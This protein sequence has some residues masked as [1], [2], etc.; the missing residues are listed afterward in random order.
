[1]ADDVLQAIVIDSGSGTTKAGFA[2]DDP[3]R[4]VIPSIVGRPR[5]Q[6]QK[7]VYVG[8]E[9]ISKAS[10]LALKFPIEHSYISNW[11]DIEKIWQH[12]FTKELHATP[13]KHPVLLTEP[14]RNPK[15]NR[16]KMMQIMFERF[17]TP[18][19]YI[20]TGAVLSL[21]ASGRTTGIVLDSGDGTTH[22]VPIYEGHALP[23][24]ITHI[25]L[26]G[27]ELNGFIRK[28]LTDRGFI[29]SSAEERNIIRDIKEKLCYVALDFKQEMAT[30]SSSS[31]LE[32][33][34]KLPDG[35]VITI[36]NERFRCPEALFQPSFLGME[37]AGIHETTY[38]SIM[39]CDVDLRKRLFANVVLSGGTTTFP[40]IA[41]RL[42]KEITSLAPTGM[43]VKINTPLERRC[44][45]WYGGSMLASMP[46]FMQMCVRK[47]TYDEIG[48]SIVHRMCY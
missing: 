30:A 6:G 25:D 36:G 4:A 24:G 39:K 12:I 42:E 21:Y 43:R 2:G 35:Q 26:A 17:G 8:D 9:A 19:T 5:G 32:K 41:D 18:A 22:A 44:S 37:T 7:S 15:A 3:P 13:E 23:Y 14:P 10:A 45:A 40:G 48:P 27:R 31:S 33:S 20:V 34:Y 47:D 11:D 29:L 38:N 1:M 46:T 16:E 28:F